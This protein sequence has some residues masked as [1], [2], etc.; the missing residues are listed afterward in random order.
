[1]NNTG[2]VLR[3]ASNVCLVI[4]QTGDCIENNKLFG[5]ESPGEQRTHNSLLQ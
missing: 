5:V 3:F 1:M 2:F 4:K